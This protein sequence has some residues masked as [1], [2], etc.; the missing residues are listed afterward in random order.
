MRIEQLEYILEVAHCQSMSKAAKKLYIS[1]PA[2]TNSINCFEEEI[3][4]KMFHR[5]SNGTIPT[6]LGEHVIEIIQD[7][8]E[9][10][11]EIEYL[12]E[13]EKRHAYRRHTS[14]VQWCHCRYH[15]L[16]QS[17]LSQ[18]DHLCP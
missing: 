6:A 5:S 11:N 4:F 17:H 1:Q 7:I 10:F 12:A 15:L 8:M 18:H 16:L 2:L 9:G 13:K 3:G 14:R